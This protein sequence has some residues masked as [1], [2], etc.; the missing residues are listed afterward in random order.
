MKVNGWE[1]KLLKIL[2]W[3]IGAIAIVMIFSG[4][5]QVG[6][7]SM[8]NDLNPCKKGM[9]AMQVIGSNTFACHNEH[10]REL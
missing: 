2:P 3:I 9:M 7:I 6:Q 5:F 8:L 4:G 1:E 10:W